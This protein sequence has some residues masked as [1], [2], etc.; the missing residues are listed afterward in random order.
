M[1]MVCGERGA[2]AHL[3]QV[4]AS[5]SSL[6]VHGT[7]MVIE[8]LGDDAGRCWLWIGSSATSANI[9]AARHLAKRFDMK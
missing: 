2:E 5:L 6:R 8:T 3:W 4:P 1:F 9:T 7:F